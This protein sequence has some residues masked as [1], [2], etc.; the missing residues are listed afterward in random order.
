MSES[1]DCQDY[2]DY[3]E[4]TVTITC[5]MSHPPH[6]EGLTPGPV[7]ATPCTRPA[8]YYA[9]IHD[10]VKTAF[11]LTNTG[12]RVAVCLDHIERLKTVTFP[13]TCAGCGYDF[14]TRNSAI[15][16]LEHVHA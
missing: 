4:S 7:K 5:F 15:W 10:C 8:A 6:N 12:T 13:V 2:F 1:P 14:P 3:L 11:L 9:D 16:N